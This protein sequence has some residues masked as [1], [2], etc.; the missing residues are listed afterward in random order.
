M[1]TIYGVNV[2]KLDKLVETVRNLSVQFEVN[3]NCWVAMVLSTGCTQPRL[4]CMHRT[5]YATASAA[6]SM[7]VIF[8]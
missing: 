8:S 5:A 7:P 6:R 3:L 1:S 2:R 4:T